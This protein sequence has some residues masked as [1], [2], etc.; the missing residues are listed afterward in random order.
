MSGTTGRSVHLEAAVVLFAQRIAE[1]RIV[2]GHADLLADD[3]FC[4]A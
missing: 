2:D 4:H 3:I 1:R